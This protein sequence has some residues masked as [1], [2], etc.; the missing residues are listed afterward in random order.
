MPTTN[1]HFDFWL[2]N[3]LD[4]KYELH[5]DEIIKR[6]KDYLATKDPAWVAYYTLD[7]I[8]VAFIGEIEGLNS[9]CERED[10]D[11]IIKLL[12]PHCK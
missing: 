2:E 8:V 3:R 10:R 9:T 4:Q 5:H 11:A 6:F 7:T 12:K 1:K